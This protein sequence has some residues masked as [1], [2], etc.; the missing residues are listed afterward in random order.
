MANYL[1]LATVLKPGDEVLIE[2]PTYELILAAAKQVGA[3]IKRFSRTAE[4]GFAIDPWQ[5][6][7][8]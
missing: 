7:G 1:A 6:S 2:H 3:T 4:S 5:W 8:R